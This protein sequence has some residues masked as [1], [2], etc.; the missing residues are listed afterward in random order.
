MADEPKQELQG[1]PNDI[2][3]QITPVIR[4]LPAAKQ[5]QIIQVVTTATQY[6]GPLPPPGM[7]TQ[8]DLIIKNG[9]E[10]ITVQF[11]AE[12]AHRRKQ[13]NKL[14]NLEIWTSVLG[15]VMGFTLRSYSWQLAPM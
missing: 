4:E 10:R 3:D 15:Q 12:A 2:V 8:Y 1:L 13:E 11:E 5:T 7:L 6:R 14:V 9:A